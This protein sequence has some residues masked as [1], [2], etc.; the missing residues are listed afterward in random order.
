MLIRE[1]EELLHRGL[2]RQYL[3]TT[4]KLESPR[5]RI[6]IEELGRNGGFREARLPCR[7]F[8][9]RINWHLNAVLRLG[10][11]AAA[12]MTHDR[13][14]RREAHR[15]ATAFGEVGEKGNLSSDGIEKAERSLTRLTAANAA[16]L[17]IIRLLFNMLGVAFEE[18]GNSIPMPG[19]LFD[20]NVFFQRLLS[21]FFQENLTTQV[22]KDEWSIR[23]VFAFAPDANPKRRSAPAPRPDFALFRHNKLTGFMDAKYRDIWEKGLPSEWLYQLSIYALA[24]PTRTSVLLYATMSDDARDERLEVRQPVQWSSQRSA[25]VILRPVPLSRLSAYVDPD[26]TLKM[27]SDRRYWAEELILPRVRETG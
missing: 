16:A 23:H 13:D 22:V 12:R 21:R 27:A 15:L 10:L 8:Q 9:R 19:F 26:E 24:S 1:I 6:A 7:H 20:M 3:P 18:R 17:R 11:V 25:S 4:E 5:G 2:A 14:L